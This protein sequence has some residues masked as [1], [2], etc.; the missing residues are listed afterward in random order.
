MKEYCIW[1]VSPPG[2]IHSHAF[3]EVALGLSCAFLK[4]GCSVS[5]V[6][7]AIHSVIFNCVSLI[8]N[9]ALKSSV[10]VA[11]ERLTPQQFSAMYPTH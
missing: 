1:I 2:Y 9:K 7:D 11:V 5:I 4:L 8:A 3:D 6:H 10:L